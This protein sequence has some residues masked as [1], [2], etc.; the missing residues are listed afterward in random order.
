MVNQP[1][2]IFDVNETLLDLNSLCPLFAEWFDDEMVM[3][4]WFANLIVYSQTVT[5]AGLQ[6]DFGA[7]AA[8]VL[9]MLGSIH[10]VE[11][12]NDEINRLRLALGSLPAHTD[13][14]ASLDHLR[15]R[16][17]RM[18]TLTNSPPSD[19]PTALERAGLA[20]YFEQAFSV[21]PSKKF[22]PAPDT[23]QLV[24]N[25]L[26]V[27]PNDL[28][29]VACHAWDTIGLQA[30]GGKGALVTHYV[31]AALPVPGIP[32]PDLVA[33]SLSALSQMISEKWC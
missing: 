17:F 16:G 21:Q 4:E 27:G 9:Q 32:Q 6:S 33:P 14:A 26:E 23:Y 13:A 12:T 2:L 31:N 7:L 29:L 5:L 18:V 22:K 20:G 15:A 11:I 10:N 19:G 30:M 3:R 24:M 1:I 8:G 28:C 25:A